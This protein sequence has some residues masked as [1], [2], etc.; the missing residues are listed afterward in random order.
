MGFKRESRR[1]AILR[2][3]RFFVARRGGK[4]FDERIFKLGFAVASELLALYSE[5]DAKGIIKTA[6]AYSH[7]ADWRFVKRHHF[8]LYEQWRVLGDA[9]GE[10]IATLKAFRQAIDED[11]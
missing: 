3:Q 11:D 10:H 1:Q 6:I 7:D 8:W 2:L 4:P 5:T 9:V